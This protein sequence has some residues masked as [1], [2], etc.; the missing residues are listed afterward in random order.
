LSERK[1]GDEIIVASEGD[2]VRA[3]ATLIKA[4]GYDHK[5]EI[6]KRYV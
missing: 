1:V 6:L 4:L 2:R 5:S 3:L